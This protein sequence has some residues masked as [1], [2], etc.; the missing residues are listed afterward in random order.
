MKLLKYIPVLLAALGLLASC[1][2]H[3]IEFPMVNVNGESQIQLHYFVPVASNTTNHIYQVDIDDVTIVQ[4]NNAVVI[5]VNNGIPGGSVGLFYTVPNEPTIKLY[6]GTDRQLVYERKVKLTPG[7]KQSVFVHDFDAD[8][9]V[10]DCGYNESGFRFD[11]NIMFETDSTGYVRFYNFLYEKPGEPYQGKLQYQGQYTRTWGDKSKTEWFN[12][13]QP[14]AFG[15]A[16]DWAPI[17]VNKVPAQSYGTTRIDY[18]IIDENGEVLQVMNASNKM[19]NYTDYWNLQ[20][21]RRYQHIFRGCRAATPNCAV[22][23]WG[24]L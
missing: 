17:T 9:V 24:A 15:E 10:I 16:T 22:S 1:E 19:V 11:T 23:S 4:P 18:R 21:G 13:G 12:V 14:V 5:N 3:E 2:K 6:K 20:P 8:P 7:R